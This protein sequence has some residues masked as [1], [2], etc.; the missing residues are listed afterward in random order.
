M[1]IV[2]W[3]KVGTIRIIAVIVLAIGI[4]GF[5]NAV[6]RRELWTILTMSGPTATALIMI[7]VALF[8]LGLR[9][10]RDHAEIHGDT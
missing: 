6:L 10:E 1:S 8:I 5:S 9:T 7:A 2:A 3:W 4:D